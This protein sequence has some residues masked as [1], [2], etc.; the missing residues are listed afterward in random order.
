MASEYDYGG[1][2]ATTAG[3]AALGPVGWALAAIN[4]GSGLIGGH[5]ARKQQR[6][7][8][9]EI[10]RRRLGLIE[11]KNLA[12]GRTAEATAAARNPLDALAERVRRESD[13]RDPMLEQALA[14]GAR[15]HLGGELR[16]LESTQSSGAQ[17]LPQQQLMMAAAL[18]QAQL[19]SESRRMARRAQSTQALGQ[20]YAQQAQITQQGAA[21]AANLESEFGQALAQLQMPSF[22]D[23]GSAQIGGLL[24]F[25]NTDEGKAGLGDLMKMFGASRG[26]WYDPIA[27]GTGAN[28]G[29]GGL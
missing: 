27:P 29:A 11:A 6:K 7:I 17:A 28:H 23:V 26:N 3:L 22:N 8:K 16:R 12:I 20:I 14:A 1:T 10:E 15:Q 18:S 21:T 25:L 2:A 24:A 9:A 4:I 13:F 19:G 5:R